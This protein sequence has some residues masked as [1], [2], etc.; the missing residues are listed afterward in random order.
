MNELFITSIASLFKATNLLLVLLGVTA[1]I[2]VGAL[3]GLT[4]TMT[5]ALLVPQVFFLSVIGSYA[6]NRNMFDGFVML[7]FGLTG[8]VDRKMKNHPGPIVLGL[9]LGICVYG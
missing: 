5:I 9:I 7:G 2:V 3:P 6:I 4:A 1:G 8:Y